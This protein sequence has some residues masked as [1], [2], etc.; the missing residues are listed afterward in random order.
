[1]KKFFVTLG[2]LVIIL[3]VLVVL[4]VLNLN[5]FI[6]QNKEYLLT[7]VEE[8]LGRKVRVEK[9]ETGFTDGIGIRMSGFSVS[10]DRDFSEGDFISAKDIQVNVAFFPLLSKKIVVTKLILSEPVITLIRNKNGDFNFS[11]ILKNAKSE[12]SGDEASKSK[13]GDQVGKIPIA[14][15]NIAIKNARITYADEENGR[16]LEARKIELGIKDLGFEKAIGVKLKAA[17]LAKDQ[18]VMLDAS[19]G[20]LSPGADFGD[21]ALK[22]DARISGLNV[23]AL[24][25]SLPMLKESI[26]KGLDFSGPVQAKLKFSGSME[27]LTLTDIDVD[28]SVFGASKPNL[29]LTGSAGP[30]GEKARGFKMDAE[31]DLKNA[32][33]NKLRQLLY[34]KD[35]IP[36]S[37]SSHGDISLRGK[38]TGTPEDFKLRGVVVDATATRIAVI[39]KFLKPSDTPL[40]ITTGAD[41][42]DDKINLRETEVKLSSLVLSLSGQINLGTTTLLN[43][44]LNSNNINMSDMKDIFPVLKKYGVSGRLKLL[45][46]KVTGESGKGQT[47]DI[48]GTLDVVNVSVKPPDFKQPI[49]D[50]NTKIEFTGN[51]AKLKDMTLRLGKS[52]VRLSTSLTSFSPLRLS[53]E[54]YS[55][56][57]DLSDLKKEN[58]KSTKPDVLKNLKSKG[59]L[60]MNNNNATFS[61]NVSSSKALLSGFE[62]MDL[63]SNLSL[64]GQKARVNSFSMKAYDGTISGKAS[65]TTGPSPEFALISTVRGLDLKTFL[66]SRNPGGK[67]NIE[68]KANLDLNVFGSGSDW[69]KIKP[70]LKGT[71]KAEVTDG[72]VLDINL[73]EEVLKGI[74]GIPGLTVFISPRVRGRYPQVFSA[75]DTEF[76]ELKASFILEKG[77]MRTNDLRVTSSDYRITGRGWIDLDSRVDMKSLLTL[78]KK[79]SEDLEE[80]APELR[81]ISSDKGLLEIPFAISGKLP[82]AKPKPDM[83][84]LSTMVQ[85]ATIKKG[86]EELKKQVLDKLLHESEKE[87]SQEADA[88]ETS[89]EQTQS[90]DAKESKKKKKR[91]DKRIL[92]ELGDLF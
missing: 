78:S 14:A 69:E 53:Y 17:I 10:D 29:K 25:K 38:A 13:G 89:V 81:Y 3:V 75:R 36:N 40:V 56:E 26:P 67:Q 28:A 39:G 34:I 7:R 90:P 8:S 65:Y 27:A 6:N 70:N 54:V 57:L 22:G 80:D 87:N 52:Q 15:S 85:R 41:I 11:T 31:F 19:I 61:G 35:S 32:N 86:K 77:K 88:E 59:S 2:A 47:P 20:P 76:E 5:Y 43:L 72:A 42:G 79:L 12:K 73:A 83:G 66:S 63:K 18:N 4:A 48:R 37:L 64:A 16:E 21:A 33:L 24:K 23:S 74:T 91:L 82:D 92:E 44:S 49:K 45:P 68:G 84:H 9:V 46:T 60:R 55:P 71:A 50:I 1:M 58:S 51:S 62:L 30:L